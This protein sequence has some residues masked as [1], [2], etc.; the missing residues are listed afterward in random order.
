[1]NV[2]IKPIKTNKNQERMKINSIITVNTSALYLGTSKRSE[3]SLTI[4]EDL[5]LNHSLF[6]FCSET[7]MLNVSNNETDNLT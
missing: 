7:W 1:M 2:N 4:I 5:V 6:I 3:I